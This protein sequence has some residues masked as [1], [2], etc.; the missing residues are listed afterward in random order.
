MLIMSETFHAKQAINDRKK[1]IL[2]DCIDDFT[3][4]KI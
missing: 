3:W 4:Y 1:K 2:N